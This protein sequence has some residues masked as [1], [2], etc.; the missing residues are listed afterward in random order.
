MFK[1][2][3]T[4]L[5]LSVILIMITLFS[6]ITIYASS[7][8][9]EELSASS[10]G[11]RASRIRLSKEIAA[12]DAAINRIESTSYKSSRN[13]R[14]SGVDSVSAKA[15]VLYEPETE[16]F[17]YEKRADLRLPMASTTKIM[18]ALVALELSSLDETVAICPEAI[19]TE[20]SSAYLKEGDVLSM[21]E[22]LYA[23][24]LQ[25]ANDAAVAIA[26]HV[27]GSIEDFA[28]LMNGKA[29]ALGLVNTHFENPHGLDSE[30]HYTT[31]RELAVIASEA[32]KNET[33]LKI[34]STH[35]KSFITEER[36]RTYVNHNK[37]LYMLDGTIGVKTGFTKRSGRCLVGA[38]EKDGLRFIS[39]TLDAPDDWNDH[40]RLMALGYDTLEKRV[41][42]NEGDYSYS[43]PVL[44]GKDTSVEISCEKGLSLITE[45]GSAEYE[46]HVR[47]SP[48][49]CAPIKEGDILGTVIFTRG[50]ET[51]ATVN[52]RAQASVAEKEKGLL[53]KILSIFK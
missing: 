39:V 16:R 2:N 17:L 45:R 5:I 34:T 42:C 4:N 38:C 31:A 47:L 46:S 28:S 41:L 40:K 52:L 37:L 6:L 19:G 25:S 36:S 14:K 3:N 30:E 53:E 21:E 9:K 27:G 13:I 18:T 29:E 33:F 49:V 7:S 10:G 43:V 23:L 35:K 1:R 11:M 48:F 22:L 15:A 12:S 44:D 26:C 20:G 8:A 51:V 50:V 32:L 24:L